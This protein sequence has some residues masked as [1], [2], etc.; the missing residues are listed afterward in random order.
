[1][2]VSAHQNMQCTL[3]GDEWKRQ[4]QGGMIWIPELHKNTTM[5]NESKACILI[6]REQI[7]FYFLFFYDEKPLQGRSPLGEREQIY[8]P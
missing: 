1:M 3:L 5:K 6:E 8:N 7:F 2:Q 4:Q